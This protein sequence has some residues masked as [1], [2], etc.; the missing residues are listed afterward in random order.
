MNAGSDIEGDTEKYSPGK[1]DRLEPREKTV[2][3]V[4]R[5]KKGLHPQQLVRLDLARQGATS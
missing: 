4:S 2:L 1:V 3:D 5:G